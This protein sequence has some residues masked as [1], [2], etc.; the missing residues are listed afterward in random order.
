MVRR[1]PDVDQTPRLPMQIATQVENADLE[2]WEHHIESNI[3]SDC[4][5]PGTEREAL[6]VARRGQGL[7]NQRGNCLVANHH[8]FFAAAFAHALIRR[9]RQNP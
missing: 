6:I 8:S 2:L 1:V 4:R 3:K 9:A 7:F 5:I